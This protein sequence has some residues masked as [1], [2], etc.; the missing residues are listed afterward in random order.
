MDTKDSKVAGDL[1]VCVEAKNAS[2]RWSSPRV[3]EVQ[4]CV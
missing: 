1:Y 2:K 3:P 4:L